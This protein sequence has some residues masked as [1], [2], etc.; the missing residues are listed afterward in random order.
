MIKIK[1]GDSSTN[2]TLVDNGMWTLK[3]Q[4]IKWN[5]EEV[6]EIK[7]VLTNKQ[8]SYVIQDVN[9]CKTNNRLELHVFKGNNNTSD[10]FTAT[11]TH[12]KGMSLDVGENRHL[13][14]VDY[15][16]D[17]IPSLQL[18][19]MSGGSNTSMQPEVRKGKILQG[20]N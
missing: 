1:K 13:D 2:Y 6:Q 4:F 10:K 19:F 14:F 7:F 5:N 15:Y 20:G 11:K 16:E 12:L 8:N 18:C 9:Y 17:K 3:G